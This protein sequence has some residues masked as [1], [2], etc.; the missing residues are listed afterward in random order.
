VPRRVVLDLALRAGL[1]QVGGLVKRQRPAVAWGDNSVSNCRS[2]SRAK[3]PGTR[4][5]A[6]PMARSLSEEGPRGPRRGVKRIPPGPLELAAPARRPRSRAGPRRAPRTCRGTASPARPTP[7]TAPPPAPA[8]SSASPG[9]AARTIPARSSWCTA[10][11]YCATAQW[12][13]DSYARAGAERS[14]QAPGS[15][16][17]PRTT[18]R[19]RPQRPAA[20]PRCWSGRTDRSAT[21]LGVDVEVILTRSY[22]FRMENH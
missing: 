19:S 20:R 3:G 2:C 5:G 22:I 14:T 11:R 9:P 13:W 1:G 8:S 4:A 12:V 6:F 7:A 18:I 10:A 15:P 21:C 17:A 16:S